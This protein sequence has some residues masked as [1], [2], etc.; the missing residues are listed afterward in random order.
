ML[1]WIYVLSCFHKTQLKHYAPEIVKK[2]WETFLSVIDTT[3]KDNGHKIYLY[4]VPNMTLGRTNKL[5]LILSPSF[6]FKTRRSFC[7]TLQGY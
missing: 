6:R 1:Q 3:I 2:N 5:V 7:L 4:I